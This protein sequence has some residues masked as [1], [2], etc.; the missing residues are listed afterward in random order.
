M[1]SAEIKFIVVIINTFIRRVQCLGK[2][3]LIKGVYEL[4]VQ[5]ASF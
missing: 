1:V 4:S 3:R 5:R 2:Q